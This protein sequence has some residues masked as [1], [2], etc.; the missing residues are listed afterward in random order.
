M[1]RRKTLKLDEYLSL[2][3]NMGELTESEQR[4]DEY[5]REHFNELIYHGIV[6]LSQNSMVS[7]A[8]IGRFLNKIGFSGYADFKRVLDSTPSDNKMI[9]PFEKNSQKQVFSSTT[10]HSVST[11][12]YSVA[13]LFNG[14]SE[15]INIT[16]LEHLIELILDEQRHIYVVGPSSSHAMAIHFSTL[17]KYFRDNITLLPTDTSELPKKLI[18][19]QEND[20]LI[21]FSYYRFNRVAL[22]IAKWFRNKNASVVLMTNSEANP[23]GKY[24]HLQFIFPS[25]VHSIFQSR[26]MGFFFI[27]LILHLAYE[28]SH[29]KSNF[30]QLEELFVF[31]ETFSATSNNS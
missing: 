17:L 22:N 4:L 5:I 1:S 14:F 21:I 11:F 18:N 13:S 28:N 12:N 10:A 8:T 31:F 26:I 20:V 23:Y 25:D 2:T 15:S 9:A 19:I 6:D 7:K 29:H 30:E 24:C 27:E 3:E 16:N